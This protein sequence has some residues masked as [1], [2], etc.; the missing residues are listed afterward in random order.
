[1]VAVAVAAVAVL[2]AGCGSGS[3]GSS[4]GSGAAASGPAGVPSAK[5][6]VS[7]AELDKIVTRALVLR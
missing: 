1:M 4:T 6:T 3:S 7:A 2:V 5:P